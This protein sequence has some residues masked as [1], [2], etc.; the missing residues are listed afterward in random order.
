MVEKAALSLVN[1][2]TTPGFKKAFMALWWTGAGLGVMGI[3]ALVVIAV[4]AFGG[5]V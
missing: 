2:S 1:V 4:A 5:W 3:S